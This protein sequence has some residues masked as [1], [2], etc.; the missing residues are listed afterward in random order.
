MTKTSSW[1][2]LRNPVFRKLW[3]A[4]LISGTCVAA[5]ETAATWL[6][7]NKGTKCEIGFLSQAVLALECWSFRDSQKCAL[8]V[9]QFWGFDADRILQ[10]FFREII[11]AE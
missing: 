1:T 9:R 3:I 6:N 10:L 11:L 4:S 5:H 8:L 7:S 2:A